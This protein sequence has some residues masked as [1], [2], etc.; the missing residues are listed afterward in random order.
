MVDEDSVSDF[1]VSLAVSDDEGS[2]PGKVASE[3]V[4]DNTDDGLTLSQSDNGFTL[5]QSDNDMEDPSVGPR[6]DVQGYCSGTASPSSVHS[7]AT[8]TKR[9]SRSR[10]RSSR[11]RSKNEVLSPPSPLAIMSFLELMILGDISTPAPLPGT[12]W[13]HHVLWAGIAPARQ[14]L[15]ALQSRP[16]LLELIFAGICMELWVLKALRC[17]C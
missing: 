11:R 8:H 16:M 13:Y 12:E 2:L 5:S 6:V 15:P 9:L 17:N 3:S 4:P 1:A 10:S 14:V 7:F